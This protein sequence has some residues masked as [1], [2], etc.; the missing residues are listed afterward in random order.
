MSELVL[1]TDCTLWSS[2]AVGVLLR[3]SFFSPPLPLP[4]PLLPFPYLVPV[5]L[6]VVV[7]MMLDNGRQAWGANGLIITGM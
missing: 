3:L 7:E 2:V 6:A 1:H 5:L 4:L